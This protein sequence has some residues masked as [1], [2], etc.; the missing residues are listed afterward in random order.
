MVYDVFLEKLR[1]LA[2]DLK[3][4]VK[5]GEVGS[6]TMRSQF[7][8]VARQLEDAVSK[9][10][11]VVT[12][13][14]IN[15]NQK[16]LFFPPT[17]IADTTPDMKVRTEETFGP[18]LPV[19]P[20][21]TVDE[22]IDIANSTEYGL[23]GSIFTMDMEEGRRIAKQLKT[24]SVNINDVLITYALPALPFGGVKHSGVGAYHGEMGLKAFSNVKS[25]T[26]FRW[27][28][29]KELF[30]YPVPEG[31]DKVA[32]YALAALFS[33]SMLNKLSASMKTVKT[34]FQIMMRRIREKNASAR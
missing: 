6:M 30:W 14:E 2:K 8:T 31:G 19:V 10:A 27:N 33:Q 32:A 12:G 15:H 13:G 34:V 24:G 29:K 23:S 26:E 9:G 17:I 20:F 25:L 11:R 4:G 5:A 21:E 18:L 16:G 1:T 3:S 22:A 7:Q 28:M